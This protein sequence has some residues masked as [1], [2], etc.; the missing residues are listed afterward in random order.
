MAKALDCSVMQL[1]QSREYRA[2]IRIEEYIT[3]TVGIPTLTDIIRELEKPG[4]D[5]RK[6]FE[7][8]QFD[9]AV[10]DISDL[11]VG[12]RLPGV[13]TNVTAF[14]AFVDIGV[15]QDGLVHISELADRFVRDPHE[16]VTVHKHVVTTVIGVDTA[17]NRISLSLRSDPFAAKGKQESP[18]SPQKAQKGQKRKRKRA[19]SQQK[20]PVRSDSPFADLMKAFEKPERRRKG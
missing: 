8:V 4:R 3:D 15:H 20:G 18:S 16:V 5:P 1:M 17:R 12:M 6:S 14:G 10:R 2:K 9:D 13:V 19:A 7:S 11:T